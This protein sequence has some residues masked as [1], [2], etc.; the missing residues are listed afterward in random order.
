MGG[1]GDR[2]RSVAIGILELW[3]PGEH[4]DEF[5]RHIIRSIMVRHEFHAEADPAR[6]AMVY[7]A[8]RLMA[9]A[10]VAPDPTTAIPCL[11]DH[12]AGLQTR[13]AEP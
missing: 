12:G 9:T 5:D 13:S 2:Q 8:G 10:P 6:Q 4:L 7:T 1:P 3:V 11:M